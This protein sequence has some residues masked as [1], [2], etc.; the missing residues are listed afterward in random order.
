MQTTLGKDTVLEVD[1]GVATSGPVEGDTVLKGTA[2][3]MKEARHLWIDREQMAQAAG[4]L[5][6]EYDAHDF[7]WSAHPLHPQAMNAE[8]TVNW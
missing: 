4:Q 8:A 6:G 5:R 7:D 3:V 1:T 2:W